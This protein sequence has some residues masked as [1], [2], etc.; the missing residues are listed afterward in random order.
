MRLS[1]SLSAERYRPDTYCWAGRLQIPGVIIPLL[2]PHNLAAVYCLGLAGIVIVAAIATTIKIMLNGY[3]P[4]RYFLFAWGAFLLG[5]L[6]IILR[7][8]QIVPVNFITAYGLQIGIALG[9][10][11]LSFSLAARIRSIK[12][13]KERAEAESRN[14]QMEALRKSE[15]AARVKSEFLANMS[16]ELRTPLNA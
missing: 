16:H 11:L 5:A 2:V 6:T 8:F 1:V 14:A 15:E 3:E 13:A 10:L 7:N 12:K 4:A 9:V